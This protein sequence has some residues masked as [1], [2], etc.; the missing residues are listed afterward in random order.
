[1]TTTTTMTALPVVS[2]DSGRWK[3]I[4]VGIAYLIA[5]GVGFTTCIGVAA[6]LFV[7]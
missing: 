7:K 2:E 4:A 5:I 3:E 1:M 6:I